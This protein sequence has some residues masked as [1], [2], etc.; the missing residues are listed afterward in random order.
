MA[1]GSSTTGGDAQG[2]GRGSLAAETWPTGPRF[3]VVRSKSDDER[4]EDVVQAQELKRVLDLPW[5]SQ[6]ARGQE[7]RKR[8]VG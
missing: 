3:Q 7:T 1:Q 5:V 6:R 2:W 8:M 4:D